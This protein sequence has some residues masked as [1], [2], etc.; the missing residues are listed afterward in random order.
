MHLRVQSID[1]LN[2]LI[3]VSEQLSHEQFK[4]SL[5]ILF[6]NSVGK[7]LRDIVEFYDL[8]VAAE[9]S[10]FVNYD[11]RSHD[12]IL[13]SDKVLAIKKM[14]ELIQALEKID[15]NKK[16]KISASYS[17]DS[18]K[19]V[20]IDSTLYREMMYNIEH[21]IHHMAI[22][23]IAIVNAYPHVNL[24][25]YFGVARSTARYNK[26]SEAITNSK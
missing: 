23:K 13:E 19:G 1:I 4:E 5:E 14:L 25:S 18:E 2:Q 17:F 6:N 22:I 12:K 15:T 26:A 24:P 8:M 10:E 20:T 7:H 3:E 21:A 16:I 11:Q 9:K